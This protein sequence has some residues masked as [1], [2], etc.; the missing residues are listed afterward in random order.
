MDILGLIALSKLKSIGAGTF[1]PSFGTIAT[2]QT[3]ISWFG[4]DPYTLTVLVDG[5]TVTDKT[6]VSILPSSGA[7]NQ[8]IAD[9]VTNIYIT[10]NNGTLTATAVGA[11]PTVPMTLQVLCTENDKKLVFNEDGS[12]TWESAND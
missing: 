1:V 3:G 12:V 10:N 11:A 5:Y 6:M 9:G 4:D 7:I 8:M 2:V